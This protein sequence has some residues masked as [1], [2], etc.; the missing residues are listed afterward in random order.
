MPR[1]SCGRGPIEPDM[2]LCRQCRADYE[3]ERQYTEYHDS[4]AYDAY[5]D[6]QDADEGFR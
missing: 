5:L 4:A 3:E 6:M 1:C 2:D